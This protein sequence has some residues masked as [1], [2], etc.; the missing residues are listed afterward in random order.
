MYVSTVGILVYNSMCML[1]EFY[2]IKQ[3][4]WHYA[5]D[6]CNLV[7][8]MLYI[9]STLTVYPTIFG[10]YTDVQVGNNMN[11]CLQN[12]RESQL[13]VMLISDPAGV[14][15]QTHQSSLIGYMFTLTKV[16]NPKKV[17]EIRRI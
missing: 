15:R 11:Y 17:I 7:S 8:W 14:N 2:N 9:S 1:R 6:P 5:V 13:R 12:S 16:N 10:R 3:Q 4:K